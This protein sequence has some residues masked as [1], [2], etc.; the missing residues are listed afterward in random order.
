MFLICAKNKRSF[1]DK[2]PLHAHASLCS[3]KM[4]ATTALMISE[5]TNI[6]VNRKLLTETKIKLPGDNLGNAVKVI[7]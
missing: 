2:A 3:T 6:Y 1:I 5:D 4:P 7:N